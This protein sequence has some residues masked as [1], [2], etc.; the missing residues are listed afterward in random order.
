VGA[1]RS[2]EDVNPGDHQPPEGGSPPETREA[3]GGKR[4]ADAPI[5]PPQQAP[6]WPDSFDAPASC[7]THAQASR[8]TQAHARL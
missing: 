2:R 3:E 4:V 5:H 7:L 8:S 6:C 1:R